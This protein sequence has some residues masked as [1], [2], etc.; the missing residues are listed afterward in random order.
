[1]IEFSN[2]II[3]WYKKEKRELPWRDTT[4]PYKIWLSEIILQQTKVSQGLPYYLKFTELFPTVE[5]LASATQEKVLNTWKG[6][7]Y[8]SRARNLHYTAKLI[9]DIYGSKFPNNYKELLTLKGVGDYTASA[10]ASFC[11][12]ESVSVVDGNVYRVLSR[13]FNL[14]TPIDS[15]TGKKEFKALAQELLSKKNPDLHNQAIMEFGA[16]QCVPKKPNCEECPFVSSCEA[17]ANKTIGELPKKQN[18]I[19]RRTRYF[20]YVLLK[21]GEHIA[22]SQRGENDIWAKMVEFPCVEAKGELEGEAIE[23]LFK[24]KFGLQL[25]LEGA[26]ILRKHVLSHQDIMY[27]I[28]KGENDEKKYS[29]FRMVLV[30]DLK[31]LPFPKLLENYILEM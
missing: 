17:Y 23:K 9:V 26:T 21:E 30:P 5:D 11:F 24:E 31:E 3:S 16:L 25:T 2:A 12:G 14:D 13:V 10:I 15:G 18:K 22:T 20:D 4:D 28:W 29:Q 6:L 1:M 7:G 8:Y 27:R 19:K